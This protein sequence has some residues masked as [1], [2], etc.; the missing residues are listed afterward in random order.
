MAEPADFTAE[1]ETKVA[2]QLHSQRV[3][4]LLGAG[5]SYLNGSGY[6]LARTA[7]ALRQPALSPSRRSAPDHSTKVILSRRRELDRP[8][9]G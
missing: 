2:Q 3:G 5:S 1:L 9:E 4:Y 8:K 7:L 6:P